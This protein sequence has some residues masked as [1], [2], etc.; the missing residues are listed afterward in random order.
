MRLPN[1]HSADVPDAKLR[2]YLLS[3]WHR[4]GRAKAAFFIA[5][6]FRADDLAQFATALLEHARSNPVTESRETAFGISYRVE[7]AL[8]CPRGDEPLVRVIWFIETGEPNPR[9]VTAYPS[10]PQAASESP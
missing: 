6:G 8:K 3:P 5:L 7:G 9:L 4:D 2:D 1:A 10:P